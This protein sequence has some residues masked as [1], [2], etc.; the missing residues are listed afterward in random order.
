MFPGRFST[1]GFDLDVVTRRVNI[2][3]VRIIAWIC[4]CIEGIEGGQTGV[5]EPGIVK[6]LSSTV[7]TVGGF[8][9]V[10]SIRILVTGVRI[11]K[12]ASRFP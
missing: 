9:F 1:I 5:C 3:V 2:E 11:G 8:L 6:D 4:V 12:R 7:Y 10:S